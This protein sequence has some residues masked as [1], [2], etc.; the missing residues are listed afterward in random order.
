MTTTKTKTENNE[1]SKTVQT[2]KDEKLIING[3]EYKYDLEWDDL[4]LLSEFLD[5][6]DYKLDMQENP[7]INALAINFFNYVSKKFYKG[8]CILKEF[9][10]K[11]YKIDEKE[12]KSLKFTG[13]LK[14]IKHLFKDKDFIDFFSSLLK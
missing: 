11:I 10:M 7:S 12:F 4:E 13:P 2:V 1:V 3:K 6:I 9:L 14:L 8:N 5:K